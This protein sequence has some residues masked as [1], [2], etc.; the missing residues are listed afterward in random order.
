MVAIDYVREWQLRRARVPTYW[1][2]KSRDL[3]AAAGALWYCQNKSRSSK[4]AKSLGFTSGFNMDIATHA[5]Y[6]MLCGMA[7][8]LALKA[9]AVSKGK[10]PVTTHDLV[11][12][13]KHANVTLF[14]RHETKVLAFLTEAIYWGGRYPVPKKFEAM[15]KLHELWQQI[16]MRPVKLGTLTMYRTLKS[17]PLDW[18][19]FRKLYNKAFDGYVSST[20]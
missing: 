9:V 18:N 5:V 16:A 1:L 15:D 20:E 8:E 14:T 7:V 6:W 4:V 13:A 19:P 11:E 2:N 12:L 10:K 3:Y 17:S